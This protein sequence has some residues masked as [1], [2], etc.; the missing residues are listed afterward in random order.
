M[1][2][3]IKPKFQKKNLSLPG[4][5]LSLLYDKIFRKDKIKK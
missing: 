3:F 1:L 4:F 5:G 2:R